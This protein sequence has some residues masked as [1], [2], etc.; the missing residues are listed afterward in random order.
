VAGFLRSSKRP[1]WLGF[2]F[3]GVFCLCILFKHPTQ[4]FPAG[5]GGNIV[6]AA[7]T[8][9]LVDDGITRYQAGDYPGAIAQWETALELYSQEQPS[10]DKTVLLENLARVYRLTGQ[11]SESIDYWEQAKQS[12]EA[13]DDF[14]HLGRLVTEQAQTFSRLGQAR[15]AIT[16]LCGN[17]GPNNPCIRDS[18]IGLAREINDPFGE[19][20]A[21]GSLGEALRL[22]GEYEG[23]IAALKKSLNLA[24][25]LNQANFQLSALSSLGAVY[26]SQAQVNYRRAKSAELAG[27]QQD[28]DRLKVQAQADDQKALEYFL[29]G[30]TL[31]ISLG[32]SGA[33]LRSQLSLIPLYRRLGK[34]DQALA[35]QVS[36]RQLLQTVPNSHDTVYATITLAN[37][38]Q[39]G[40]RG[41]LSS[42]IAQCFHSPA[43]QQTRALLLEAGHQAQTLGDFRG[44]AFA[45][46]ALGH[47]FECQGNYPQALQ[48]TQQAQ[49]VADQQ[50]QGWDS[51][52]LWQWQVGRILLAQARTADAIQA[53]QQAVTTLNDI[54]N[55]LLI[56]DRELQFDFRDTVEPIYR[57]L[58]AL[59]LR[60]ATM[61]K[62]RDQPAVREDLSAAL[63]TLESLKLIELQNYFGS[64][65]EIIPFAE[66]QQGLI[67]ANSSTTVLN[68][69]LLGDQTAMIASF[70]NGDRQIA[71]IP[72]DDATLRKTIN[73][74]R[75][76]LE[77]YFNPFDD[78]QLSQAQQIYDWLI[79]PFTDQLQASQV[80]T[81][82]FVNDGILRSIP[83]A[84]LHDGQRFL[85]ESYGMATI[86]TLSLTAASTL[87]PQ[88]MRVLV[89]GLTETI[90][91]EDEEFPALLYVD[92]EVDAIQRQVTNTQVLLDQDFN[93]TRMGLALRESTY[94]VL[95]IATHGQFEAEPEQ[96]FLLTGQGEKLTLAEMEQLIR[97]MSANGE[98]IDLLALTACETAIGD[99]RAALGLGGVAVRA[100]AKSAIASLWSINDAATAQF[101]ALFYQNLVA[102]QLSKAKALQQAQMR[103]IQ[104]NNHP[105]YWSPYV[106]VGNWL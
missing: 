53:Y 32:D 56:S 48:F 51:L 71:W 70:P 22:R 35:A 84:A 54:R 24:R 33:E 14:E 21:L 39:F 37:L 29:A 30:Q 93:L 85:V 4:G 34:P 90:T 49:G 17:A 83:M 91:V 73:D 105:A 88:R 80:D 9:Q 62:E 27:D 23:A 68:S 38:I 61:V 11:L 60:S 78:L 65:C 1:H 55:D 6:Q 76:G 46:G 10:P 12:A 16:L 67:G 104:D 106:L 75:R 87:D 95:H 64:E 101:S 103:M 36:A 47:W 40:E 13:L 102:G 94:S 15:R 45:W 19:T 58:I 92:D 98:S 81:L 96:T 82:V 20:A 74:Y 42:T 77:S 26:A 28:S 63:G 18:A 50:N 44:E 8:G 79:R 59:Q 69:V 57:Q 89:M 66:I 41:D 2:L 100:G 3:L 86:P 7:D 25:T 5:T 43:D 97:N 72:V 99:E 52:Y 31:A